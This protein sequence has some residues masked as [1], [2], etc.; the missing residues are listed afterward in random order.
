MVNFKFN[1]KDVVKN[2]NSGITLIALVITVIVLLILAGIS[3][4]MLAGDNSILQKATDAKTE[5]ERG[6]VYEQISLATASGEME[7][8]SN[9]TDRLIAYKSALLNGVDGIDR[10]NLKDNGSN[11]ITGTV[12]TKS[13]KQYDFSVPVP[14]TDITL[15]EHKEKV[16]ELTSV[17]AKL[18]NDGT[19]ILSST[20][21][22]DT[23]KTLT[24]D[25]KEVKNKAASNYWSASDYNTLVTKVSFYDE[26]VP[27]TTAYY[28]N[29]LTNLTTFE[30]MNNLE[31]SLVTNMQSMFAGCTS[32]TSIDVSHFNTSNVTNMRFMFAGS[33]KQTNTP[34]T[35]YNYYEGNIKT[36]NLSNF[37][38]GKVTD[39]AGMFAY[40]V[41][42]ETVNLS[43][44][45]TSNV[46][47]MSYMFNSCTSLTT[48]DLSHFN[49][50][51]VTDMD[52]MFRCMISSGGFQ[53]TYYYY[54]NSTTT[55][56]S[57]KTIYVSDLW[58]ISKVR[59]Q[60]NLA[61]RM[62][63]GCVSLVGAIS[64][65]SSK[66]DQT[67]ANYTTGYLTYKSNS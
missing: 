1:K 21:Y 61:D 7:Y 34:T 20:D 53:P 66:N 15:A 47:S 46:T 57:L 29:D 9:G 23:S 13:G 27:S 4:S 14:V 59:M 8:Y 35:Q 52:Q 24:K 45:D 60:R 2:K 10:N 44:F 31:T 55:R 64:Y 54:N 32:L 37:D 39:M 11:L 25:F 67:Y 19:L 56:S 63:N 65:D 12:T 30:N 41:S 51:N 18:Y 38:T 49:T 40:Q 62:F 3:I 28:F 58:D 43:S 48:L 16:I 6:E 17:Y 50:S 36:L 42:L 33:V 5:T 22:T 26:I